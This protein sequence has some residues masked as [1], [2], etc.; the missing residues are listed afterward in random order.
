MGLELPE[1]LLESLRAIGKPLQHPEGSV[2]LEEGGP[3]AEGFFLILK[4][5]VGL[6]QR[7]KKT[8][9][10]SEGEVFGLPSFLTREPPSFT[11]RAETPLEALALPKEGLALLLGHPDGARFLLKSLVEEVGQNRL[12]TPSPLL[13]PA[14]TLLRH[15]P[16]FISKETPVQ[17]AAQKMREARVSSLLLKE[18][19]G[20]LTDRDLRNRVLAEG[21]PPSTPVEKVASFPL[22]AL[23]ADTPLYEA[24]AFM[25]ERGIHH[26]PLLEGGKVVGVITHRDLLEAQVQTPLF[27]LKRIERLD[28]LSYSQEIARLVEALWQGG[29]P[30]LE[31]G[32]VVASLN[33]ALIRRLLKEAE[34]RLGPPP[35]PYAFM[36][37]GSE[38]RKEQALL[39]DQDNALVLE[40]EA[41]EAYFQA[42][43]QE[44][45]D[46][47]HRAGFPY[48]K[49]GYMATSHRRSLKAWLEL[50]RAHLQTPKPQ[51]LLE[52]QI[53]FDFR[54]VYGELSLEP[55]ERLIQEE[56]QR[57]V[58]LYH[59][60]Q[61]SLAFRPPLGFLGRIQTQKGRVDLK[62]G[63]IAPIVSLA[64]LYGLLAQS[65]E[66]GTLARLKEAAQR[67]VLSLETAEAL[68]EA[69][70]F[71]FG[72]R[73]KHQLQALKAGQPLT[74][75][76]ALKDLSPGE[77]KRL[78]EAFHLIA[79]IQ[80]Y[81]ARRFQIRT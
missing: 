59:L 43:A 24:M 56:A 62:R 35:F 73:L 7:G 66:K 81:T 17:Q 30:P 23:P 33:D 26:L 69:Y 3:P 13:H 55:L 57:G 49:G 60:A 18:P 53:F 40:R 4:G 47:L 70:A 28:L 6:Y 27:L 22:L 77:E 1:K 11:A 78:R 44:V 63:G 54:A 41:E 20:I 79:Q 39:T 61:S 51:A 15:P 21:L 67:G 38:G 9:E 36:V 71:L 74:N 2:L 80:D 45:V 8:K 25:V 16:L 34:A 48:C 29:L 68:S 52:A 46:G 58:F 5:R 76:V 50:F 37:F 14:K 64:R 12:E 10:V 75:E 42:L 32:H 31:I 19:P 65:R 72:L